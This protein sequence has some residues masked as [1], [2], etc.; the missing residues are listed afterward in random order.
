M[1]I[2]EIYK[3]AI[4]MGIESD[5]R[6]KD[7]VLKQLKKTKEKYEK[8]SKEEKAEFDEEKLHN[9]YSD[10]RI[11]TGDP[12]KEIKRIM[13]GIDIDPAELMMARYLSDKGQ[14]IDLVMGHH[15]IGSALNDIAGVMHLQADILAQYGV[16]INIAE[17][18]MLPR[19][20]E[21]SQG[22]FQAYNYDRP[23]QAAKL[24]GFPLMCIHTP[25]DNLVANHIEKIIKKEKPDTVGEV[26]KVLND[27]SEYKEA[28]KYKAG[29]QIVVGRKEARSG[30]IA[31]DFTGGTNGA[32]EIFKHS[33][34]AGIGTVISMHMR[35]EWRKE[36]EKHHIN[37]IICGDT[38]SDSIGMNLFLD[39]LEKKGI[40][41][42]P[43]SGL[44]RVKRF[45]KK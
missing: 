4:K 43:F 11:L 5:L 2:K 25:A 28:I 7:F 29:P 37:V 22:I 20:T 21:I 24:L 8:L 44:M 38:Q 17:A 41:I 33:S 32:K 1:K 39:E 27:I 18:V 15:P 36:A 40:D 34:H 10:S 9:P 30:K 16:P 42:I 23:V 19:I 31:V 12:N 3:L 35:E 14:E 6:G 26:L 13:V 45:K